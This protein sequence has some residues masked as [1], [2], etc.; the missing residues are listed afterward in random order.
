MDFFEAE[1]R[2]K[3]R[4]GWLIVLFALAVGGTVLGVYLGISLALQL[5]VPAQDPSRTFANAGL[6]WR[7]AA[8]TLLL[9][10]AASIYKTR[11]VTRSA[12][13]VALGLGGR[14]VDPDTADPH[15][16]RL[17]NVVE[18]MA[19]A[20]GVPVPA[21]HLL[22]AEPG[23][24]AF[25]VGLDT[26][27]SSIAVT[28]GCMRKLSR[29]EL[30]GVIAHEFSHLL[31]GDARLNLRLLGLVHGILVIGLLGSAILRSSG[32]SGGGRQRKI[33]S[34]L[35]ALLVTGA[36][37]YA[38]GSIGVFFTRLIK[39]AVSR[40]RELLADASGVQFTRNPEG[41]AGALK[42]IG[43]L[44]GGSRLLAPRA[45]EASH[46]YF[47]EGMRF[48]ALLSTHPPLVERI[49]LLDPQFRGE[50]AGGMIAPAGLE[51]EIAGV[52]A[53][54]PPASPLAVQPRALV[55]SVGA[56]TDRHIAYAQSLL[57]HIPQRLRE[58]IRESWVARAVVLALLLDRKPD[59]RAAQLGA[60]LALGDPH[61]PD[62]VARAS[63]ALQAVPAEA[64]LPILDL[65]LPA[66]RKLSA[67]QYRALSTAVDRMVSADARI[68][69]FEYTLQRV[70]LRH[71]SAHFGVQAA[72]PAAGPPIEV[73]EALSMLL[74]ML[75]HAGSAD[76]AEVAHAF[77]AAR[78]EVSPERFQP[79]LLPRERCSLRA[80]DRALD[81]LGDTAPRLRAQI[82]AA[83]VAAVAT[84]GTVTAAEGE[85]LRAIADS[86]GC[87][88]PPL[89][90]GQAVASGDE[91]R[92]RARAG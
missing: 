53:A 72:P 78:K 57:A 35:S 79:A 58:A 13:S 8:S 18:E 6:F 56:L 84:D 24:N 59:T 64:R 61:L 39:A 90:P 4:T 49:R 66:L 45:E 91:D 2:A 40:Q 77:E 26:S 27:R 87:P 47:S 31:N 14:P 9:I 29:D 73:V 41:L 50:L 74:S 7:V 69:L 65:A 25:A 52:A 12:D 63:A 23:I 44:D 82:L 33:G 46:F 86:L 17:L 22:P 10:L 20:S 1:A 62:Q 85:L 71:L 76:P 34:G 37:L 75:A 83:C 60:L 88:M 28:D 70:L 92:V 48:T 81:R 51:Q 36:S 38:I 16:R 30:Q 5:I 89:L 67:A 54:T 3:R 21:V 19:V 11:A 42:K 43:G 80:L 55:R 32:R 15:E 68:D